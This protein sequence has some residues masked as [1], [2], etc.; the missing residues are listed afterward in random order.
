MSL[1][2]ALLRFLFA[3]ALV[4]SGSAAQ[5]HSLAHAQFDLAAAAQG[6]K[7]P[8]PLKHSTDQCLVVHAL[9]GTAAESGA[10][11][12]T[13]NYAHSVVPVANARSGETPAAAFLSRAPPLS[14]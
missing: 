4:Y 6:H 7:A 10:C 13:E 14:A 5:L 9:D 11:L 8:S 1:R 12:A 2:A 3:L